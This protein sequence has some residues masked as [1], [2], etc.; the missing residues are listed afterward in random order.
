MYCTSMMVRADIPMM[1]ILLIISVS[2]LLLST[3]LELWMPLRDRWKGNKQS[4]QLDFLHL[5][6]TELAA[7]GLFRVVLFALSFALGIKLTKPDGTGLWLYLGIAELPVVLQF[8]IGMAILD[9]GLYW[10]H[11]IFHM[12]YFF[13]K[14]HQVH[15]TPKELTSI[16]AIRNHLIGPLTTVT[17]ILIFGLIGPSFEVFVMVHAWII[18]KGWL[19]H[20]NANLETGFFDYLFPTPNI[21]RWHHSSI[22]RE[23]DCNFGILSNFWD[24]FPWHRVPFIGKHLRLQRPTFYRPN[25]HK[26]PDNLGISE[27]STE[28]KKALEI[29]WMQF[30]R[31]F[32]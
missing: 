2:T 3:T 1:L 19:Q 20:S 27:Y 28:N 6:F 10:Q 30:S 26:Y 8:F 16:S 29:W 31:P 12:N 24:H 9:L 22:R 14:V 18:V 17:V 4:F 7:Q 23:A 25:N 11:R 32:K 5:I 15:H 13:W 21:H